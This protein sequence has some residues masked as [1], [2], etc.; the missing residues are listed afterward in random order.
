LSIPKEKS[1]PSARGHRLTA[2]ARPGL[3]H[4][5]FQERVQMAPKSLFLILGFVLLSGCSTTPVRERIDGLICERANQPKDVQPP[6]S[7][8]S[9]RPA[10]DAM[11]SDLRQTAFQAPAEQGAQLPVPRPLSQLTQPPTSLE[12]RLEVPPGVPGAQVPPIVLPALKKAP[13]KEIDAAI[14]KYFPPLPP[15]GTDPGPGTGPE[16]RPLTLTDLQRLAQTNSPLLRQAASDI[17]AAAGAA[18]QAGAYPNPTVGLTGQT[19]GPGGGPNYGGAIGQTIKTPGKLKLAQAP[20]TMDLENAKL[21]YRRAETDL[22]AAVRT[23]YFA[24]LVAQENIRGNRALV[25]LTDEVYK[26]NVVQL[27]GGDVATYEPMQLGVFAVQARTALVT[28]RNNYTVAW[29]QLAAAL[30]LPAL[31]PTELAGRIHMPLPVWRYDQALAHVL[32]NHT[33]VLTT[34]NTI[35]KARFNLRLAQITPYPDLSVQATVYND[36][37]PPGPSRAVAIMTASV[38]VPLF[39]R[40]QGAIRQAQ[41]ALVRAIEEPHRVQDD[42]TG[43]VADAFR[44]Y[45]ENRN[46][47]ELYVKEALPK[48]V[49]AFRAAVKRHYGGEPEKVAYTD[50]VSAEQNLVGVVGTYLTLLGA[51]WQAVVD[52]A[53]LLQTDDLFQLAE[54]LEVPPVPDLEHLLELPCCHPCSPLTDPALKGADL[55]WRSAAI[56]PSAMS[57]QPA[58]PTPKS[59]A[60]AT[61]QREGPPPVPV[62]VIPADTSQQA[63]S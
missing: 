20:A 14:D 33:D 30:G 60:E 10:A 31:P 32:T 34:R 43:R 26:V 23:G 13:K 21:A 29:K 63:K 46:L 35:D 22:M 28:A 25:K 15:I 45:D 1:Y 7:P 50:L 18:K 9:A 56:A 4:V 5:A 12:K 49:Q 27:K 58:P 17:E 53:S 36:V 40:N 2:A 39:D 37:T 6:L 52:L 62:I 54:H 44:R 51:Q 48:Q 57:T 42:L 38:P 41:A 47:V 61:R 59:Q 8:D 55:N 3:R 16:G 11:K 24:V 19:Q